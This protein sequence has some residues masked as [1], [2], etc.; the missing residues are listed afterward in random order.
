MKTLFSLSVLVCLYSF[1]EPVG[2]AASS[3]PVASYHPR[4]IINRDLNL[5]A[6]KARALGSM[7]ADYLT[8]FKYYNPAG[9]L[10][11]LTENYT[12]STIYGIGYLY[13]MSGDTAYAD[14]LIDGFLLTC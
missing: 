12:M 14:K 9:D 7:N 6:L 5:A 2:N 4:I 13:Q 1:L 8:L 3:Y 11:S 10:C